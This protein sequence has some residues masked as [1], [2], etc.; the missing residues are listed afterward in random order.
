MKIPAH[1]I[2]FVAFLLL[3]LALTP[4]FAQGPVEEE[5]KG[6][7]LKRDDGRFLQIFIQG[8]QI[9]VHFFDADRQPIPR[10]VLQAVIHYTPPHQL[11]RESVPMQPAK[12]GDHLETRRFI[13]PPFNFRFS[14]VL[15]R[16]GTLER[17]ETY[18]G[19]LL[20]EHEVKP[21]ADQPAGG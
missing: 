12:E 14:L 13:R 17:T 18:S 8:N 6:L 20:P 10:D 4:S 5:E 2:R 21:E 11:A 1:L 16:D 15:F 7:W 19:R 9:Q 3:L